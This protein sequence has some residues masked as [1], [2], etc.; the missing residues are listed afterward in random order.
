MEQQ[1][2]ESIVLTE[3]SAKRFREIAKEKGYPE[4]QYRV[5]LGVRAGGCAGFNYQTD[6]V[7]EA[8]FQTLKNM[9]RDISYRELESQGLKIVIDHK[10]YPFLLGMCVDY[11]S[12]HHFRYLNPQAKGS[13][14]CGTSFSID[15]PCKDNDEL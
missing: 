4:G 15:S 12:F 11:D 3:A 2:L 6:I 10:S 14:G 1:K 9:S 5:H 13:C 7:T 8:E